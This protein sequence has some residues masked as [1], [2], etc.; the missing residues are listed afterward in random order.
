MRIKGILKHSQ[1]TYLISD[2]L[3]KYSHKKIL[4]KFLVKV[5]DYPEVKY[6]ETL[7][8]AKDFLEFVDVFLWKV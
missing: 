3:Q 4:N 2:R 1:K 7:K 5:Q 8:E 6:F